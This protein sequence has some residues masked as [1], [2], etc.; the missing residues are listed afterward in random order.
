M[1]DLSIPKIIS[2]ISSGDIRIPAFQREFVWDPN[3]VAF[4]LDSVYKG[5]PVGT[6][7]FWQTSE[8]LRTEKKLG[9]FKLPEPQKSYPVNYVLDGQQRLTSLF[10]AFQFEL[11]PDSSDW[12]EIYL[13]METDS[14]PEDVSFSA[15]QDDEVDLNRYFPVKSF[16]DPTGF[17]TAM[18]RLTDDQKVF[19]NDVQNKLRDFKIPVVTFETDD[20][21]EVAIV[22]ERI[23]RAGTELKTF[24]LLTAWSWS[25]DFDL[26][27][28]F[29]DLQG[30]I[31]G[32]G[33]HDLVSDR[34][35]QLRICS[36]VISGETAAPKILDLSGQD[37]RDRFNEIRNGILGAIDFLQN[38]IGVKHYKMLP[39][40]SALIP[41]SCY[42]STDKSDGQKYDA[43]QKEIL[44]KWFW[45]STLSRRF[46]NDVTERQTADIAEINKLKL[47]PAH[48]FK[49]P[50][51]ELRIDFRKN[52]FSAA[53]GN[54]KALILMLASQ[55][56]KSFLSNSEISVVDVLK[57]GSKHEF[58]HIFPKNHLKNI[59]ILND[60]ANVLANLCYLTRHDNNEI[61][62]KDPADYFES[63][64]PTF[65]KDI[66]SS[67]LVDYADKDLEYEDFVEARAKRLE[68][69]VQELTDLTAIPPSLEAP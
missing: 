20:K 7:V 29:E 32:A 10:S 8:R 1:S 18:S 24:E 15:L 4:L 35:L 50:S 60:R 23:N 11:S 62:D 40:P 46:S 41:L 25:E 54:S 26:I 66:L 63:I 6:V 34:E 57:K 38:Q 21:N 13:D 42:F 17:Y 55:R 44:K 59:G 33:F 67:A 2:K 56:P 14:H 52:R 5:F 37:I 22:F 68:R 36:A 65:R 49:F 27:E 30:D 39:F 64:D 19:V 3:Q 16:F 51:F 12:V 61:K 43:R 45:I 48:D 58:H 69:L 9:D 31:E 47:N 28:K 53:T